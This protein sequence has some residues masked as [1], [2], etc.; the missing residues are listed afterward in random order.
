MISDALS[1]VG[2]SYQ[3]EDNRR[4]NRLKTLKIKTFIC[5][6]PF[7]CRQYDSGQSDTLESAALIMLNLEEIYFF[8]PI[9]ISEPGGQRYIDTSPRKV[10]EDTLECLNS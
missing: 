3:V 6:R 4:Y 1:N 10:S 2:G 5:P 8:G 9:Q 7:G